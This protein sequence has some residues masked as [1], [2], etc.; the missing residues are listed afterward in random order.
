MDCQRDCKDGNG[1]NVMDVITPFDILGVD[2]G[3]GLGVRA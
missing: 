1:G 3:A 2:T